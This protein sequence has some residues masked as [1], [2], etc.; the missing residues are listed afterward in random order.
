MAVT[1]DAVVVG[2]GPG[3][4]AAA[5]A[6][7]RQGLSV[8]MLEAGPAFEAS[9]Y[10][11]ASQDWE[12]SGFPVKPGSQARIVY[13][14]LGRLTDDYRDL[15]AFN[16]QTPAAADQQDRLPSSTGYAHVMGVGG[17]SLHY[18]GEAH[19][20]HPQSFR[21]QS[22]YGVG[23]DWPF[24][25]EELEPY[26][27]RI[28]DFVGVAGDSAS[29]GARWRSKPFPL[30]PHP[31]SPGSVRLGQAAERL[32]WTWFVNSRAALSQPYAGRPPCNYC[33]Q[34]PRGCPLGDKGSADVTYL[35]E[36]M[37]SGKLT[38][39]S[40]APVIGFD[41]APGGW[42]SA[43]RYV[44][45]GQEMR[46]EAPLLFLAAGAVQT[47]RLLLGAKI[48]DHPNGIAN[49]SGQVGRNFMETL[50]YTASGLCADLSLSQRGLPA[51][52]VSWQFNAP[53]PVDDTV[54]GFRMTA[55]LTET[56]LNGPI[57]HGLRLVP[58]HG[59]AFKA[60]IRE[61]FGTALSL[62]AIGAVIPDERSFITVSATEKD[63]M[64]QPLAE[65][66]S[67]LTEA[68][69][70]MLARMAKTVRTMLSEAGVG[71]LGEQYSSWDRFTATHVFGTC[72]MGTDAR[73][74]VVDAYSR[75][76]DHPNLL[77]VD[78]SVFPTSGGGESPSLTIAA[79][80]L[81]A[82]EHAVGA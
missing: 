20:L 73:Q 4:A 15:T 43:V 57:G 47:P 62:S 52:A 80:S 54:G 45:K 12:R 48:A 38:L 49:S 76:H 72:R 37:L 24:G 1:Y 33:G 16:A 70:R 35:A 69:L 13:G 50:F 10:K 79:L 59:A 3:G 61:T 8:L 26:Y 17:S 6:L 18:T 5:W 9:D 11:A 39:R 65:I 7:T 21:L 22:S 64:G 60:K 44:H 41:V 23:A 34:C 46:Q 2:S 71:D 27:F 53:D 32:G 63:R 36:A 77:I 74:S 58:G 19:R 42:I 67:V 68:S 55:S 29:P 40:E 82:V 14:D 75:S 31:L 78:G 81:R 30:P 56:G 25:Y 66:H 51:D 28:E